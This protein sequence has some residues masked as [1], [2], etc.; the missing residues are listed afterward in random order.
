VAATGLKIAQIQRGVSVRGSVRVQR[1]G[2]R[3]RAGRASFTAQLNVAG[4]SA[5]R[6]NGRLAITLRL[7]VA[8]AEGRSY[9][10]TRTVIL[11]PPS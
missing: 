9:T 6:R 2:S 1:A 4:R 3:L 11:R 8:P 10:A 5:L 7:T